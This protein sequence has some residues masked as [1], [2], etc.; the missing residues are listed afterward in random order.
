MIIDENTKQGLYGWTPSM[1]NAPTLAPEIEQH[2]SPEYQPEVTSEMPVEPLT[3][4]VQHLAN[5]VEQQLENNTQEQPIVP[6]Q[7]EVPPVQPE[8][9]PLPPLLDEKEQFYKRQ[10]E[11]FEQYKQFNNK[12]M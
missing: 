5:A 4:F 11:I 7:P 2:N 1:E 10:Q 3:L 12:L 6:Q 8:E 9:E